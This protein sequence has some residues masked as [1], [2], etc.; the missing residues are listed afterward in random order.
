MTY[1]VRWRA[2]MFRQAASIKSGPKV[3]PRKCTWCNGT[4]Q[5]P[6]DYNDRRKGTTTCDRCGGCGEMTS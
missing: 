3:K 1:S 5:V 6:V 2:D 4:G